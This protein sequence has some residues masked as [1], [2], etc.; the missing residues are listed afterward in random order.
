MNYYKKLPCNNYDNINQEILNHVLMTI[1]VANP[2]AF[3][4]PVPV[5][6]FVKATPLF[7]TWLQEQKLQLRALAVTI[8]ADQNCCGP[9]KDTP[10]ARFKLSWPIQNSETTFNRFFQPLNNQSTTEINHL[11]GTSYLNLDELTEVDRMRVDSPALIDA[12]QLH[13]VWF[14]PDSMFPRLGLQCHLMKEP[15]YL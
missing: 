9:H 8:G 15:E 7:Q 3:W 14:E 13:D 1:D 12:Q 10:P 11:G 2:T 4:N 6:D 5:I